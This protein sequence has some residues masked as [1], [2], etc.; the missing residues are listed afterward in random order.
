[1][2]EMN[3]RCG[4]TE[5][6]AMMELMESNATSGDMVLVVVFVLVRSVFVREFA[7]VLVRRVSSSFVLVCVC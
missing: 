6:T 3:A 5:Q 2:T 7:F 1:M 4:D